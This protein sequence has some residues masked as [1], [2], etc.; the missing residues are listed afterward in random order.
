MAD[1]TATTTEA[2]PQPRKVREIAADIRATWKNIYFGA[3]PY[4]EAM[5]QFDS[6]DD[7]YI[8]EKGSGILRRFL[9]NAARWRGEDARRIKAEIN[10]LLGD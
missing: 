9:V 8:C 1:A 2:A 7:T 10:A 4:V 3:E 6:P 5:E